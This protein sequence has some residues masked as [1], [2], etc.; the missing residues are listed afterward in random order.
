ML[1]WALDV[2]KSGDLSYQAH[3]GPEAKM[4]I[5]TGDVQC[6]YTKPRWLPTRAA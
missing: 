1:S 6:D 3:R 4:S 5:K 2:F